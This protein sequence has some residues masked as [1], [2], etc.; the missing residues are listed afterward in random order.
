MQRRN[1]HL[2][3]EDMLE[4]I[5]KIQR[6]TYGMSFE[7]FCEDEKT[8]D[9]VIRNIEIIGEASGHI[10]SS[11]KER[12]SKIPWTEM[13]GIRNVLIHK[14]FGVSLSIVWKTVTDNLPP[15][16]PMLKYVLKKAPT[17]NES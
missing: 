3:V 4:A 17:A 15:L 9:A 8:V 6:Y 5:L 11:I 10:P 16:V 7:D 13:R 14:Y 2:Y 12:H 1:W